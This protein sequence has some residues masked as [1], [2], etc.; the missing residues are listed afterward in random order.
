MFKNKLKLDIPKE[1]VN[2]IKKFYDKNI[3]LND[4]T[5]VG[6]RL[7]ILDAKTF[8]EDEIISV[9]TTHYGC[10]D[11]GCLLLCNTIIGNAKHK[12]VI[13]LSDFDGISSIEEVNDWKQMDKTLTFNIGTNS[14]IK[15]EKRL[16]LDTFK[17]N[18]ELEP[19]LWSGLSLQPEVRKRLLKIVDN[20]TETLINQGVKI[21][22]VILVGSIVNYHWSRF[23][24]IDLHIKLDFNSVN[25]DEDLAKFLLDS[26]KNSWND[27][28]DIKINGYDVEIYFQDI[29]EANESGGI[30][31][32]TNNKWL[33]EPIK[34]EIDF[35]KDKM[36]K[37]AL[38]YIN[39][40]D[41]IVEV[42]KT[43]D[44]KSA[45]YE[46]LSNLMDKIKSIRK[47]GLE[48][49]GEKSEE[50]IF[51][52]ILRRTNTIKKIIDTKNKIYDELLSIK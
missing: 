38:K 25:R 27:T 14:I 29:D 43:S 18:D 21:E 10:S 7:Y 46:T 37:K 41:D 8:K 5:F 51:F 16:Y 17:V 9:E 33:K 36:K 22:D 45:L 40:V 35:D 42:E 4:E 30:Y 20:A 31:S 12:S 19:N 2:I 44:N 1:I 6:D 13:V 48:E 23:S 15:E 24:D 26:V 50:N 47:K 28:H 34:L 32:I 11:K 39:L 49:K 3:S 52:K